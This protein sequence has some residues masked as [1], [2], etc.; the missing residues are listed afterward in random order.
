MYHQA[1]FVRKTVARATLNK[2]KQVGGE[3][4]KSTTCDC[5]SQ[6]YK[7]QEV[8]PGVTIVHSSKN[9]THSL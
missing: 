3:R 1:I 7:S 4:E 9:S 6:L 5:C 2:K 8:T